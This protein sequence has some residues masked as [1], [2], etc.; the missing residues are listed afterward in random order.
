MAGL[1]LIT[2]VSPANSYSNKRFTLIIIYQLGLVQQ[3]K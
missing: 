2:S 3:A 1:S